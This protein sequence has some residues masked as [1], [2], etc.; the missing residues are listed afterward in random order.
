MTSKTIKLVL[1]AALAAAIEKAAAERFKPPAVYIRDLLVQHSRG[2]LSAPTAAGSRPIQTKHTPT[3]E[4][5]E[6]MDA[7][8]TR[9]TRLQER[10]GKVKGGISS[11]Q[12]RLSSTND[13]QERAQFTAR[14]WSP[15]ATA[16]ILEAGIA[17]ARRQ[18]KAEQYADAIETLD[19]A[20]LAANDPL[21]PNQKILLPRMMRAYAAQDDD[22]LRQ[23]AVE[24]Q[25]ELK[26]TPNS[27]TFVLELKGLQEELARRADEDHGIIA[28][29]KTIRE[30]TPEE[31]AALHAWGSGEDLRTTK[32]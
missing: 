29:P 6:L 12:S 24:V 31:L 13:D 17:K 21:T 9:L 4:D 22:T 19:A 30:Q 18:A 26:R 10:L 23:R 7:V 8:K 25:R 28:P 5:G 15:Q 16:V 2:E 14:L 20:E 32:S 1:P 3:D 11:L 27:P